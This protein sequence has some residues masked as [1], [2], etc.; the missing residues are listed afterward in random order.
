MIVVILGVDIWYCLY[1]WVFHSLFFFFCSVFLFVSLF[2][3]S[4]LPH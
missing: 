3:F 1:G 4:L 2:V